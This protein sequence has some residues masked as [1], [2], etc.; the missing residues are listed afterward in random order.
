MAFFVLQWVVIVVGAA[1]HMLLDR[2]P[3]RRTPRRLVELGL[4]WVLVAG[5]AWAIFGGFGHIGPD[6]TELA[7]E[8]GYR[9]SFFQ[10]E[11][12]WG[13]IAIGVLGVMCAWMR[14]SFMTAAVIALTL[15]YGGDAIGHV[16]QLVEHDNHADSNVWAI[17]SDILQPVA[18]I[19]LLIAY[20]TMAPKPTPAPARAG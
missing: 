15:S 3:S 6:S 17:P 7:E 9:Q 8:I 11:V 10:W 16:M 5:G 19:V 13:D 1:V 18:A 20:R 14:D 4:L 2:K 12:G